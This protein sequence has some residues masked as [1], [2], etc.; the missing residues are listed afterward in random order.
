MIF[1]VLIIGLGS[2]GWKYD[3]HLNENDYILTHA[4][5]FSL[6]KNFKLVGG[7]DKDLSI[8]RSFR[9]KYGVQGVD[10]LNSLKNN[11]F[12]LIVISVP[13]INHLNVFKEVIS[14]LNSKIILF[15]KPVGLNQKERLEIEKIAKKK[16]I[17]IFVNYMRQCDPSIIDVK[18]KIDNKNIKTPFFGTLNYTGQLINNCSHFFVLF[19]SFMGK[20]KKIEKISNDINLKSEG[21][22]RFFYTKGIVDFISIKFNKISI[23]D[24]KLYSESG[25][26]ETKGQ[27]GQVNWTKFQKSNVYKH[28][29]VLDKTFIY[30][31]T[32]KKAMY[33]VA[34]NIHDE[35]L[36]KSSNLI[37]LKKS[38]YILNRIEKKL[39][40][41]NVKF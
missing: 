32:G 12:D 19:E 5:A 28:L 21:D 20:L 10:S 18:N 16:S 35:F 9:K 33:Y 23:N 29:N 6:H 11:F 31:E 17:N 1:E 41:I 7:V 22:F 3:N 14:N 8:L 34:Q 30:K 24:V 2:I 4:R 40:N 15:E 39:E 37:T 13:T 36:D 27:F 26:L 25:C 38:N